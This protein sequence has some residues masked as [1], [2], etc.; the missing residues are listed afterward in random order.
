MDDARKQMIQQAFDTVAEGYD[1]P[2]LAFFSDT[3]ERMLVH[4]AMTDDLQLLDVCTGTGMLALKA[5]NQLARGRV[6]GIDLSSGMLKQASQKA[7]RLNL[8]NTDFVQ[9]DLDNLSLPANSFDVATSSFG[10]FFIE[11]MERAL[12]NIA[13]TVKPGGKVAISSFTGNAFQPFSEM[14]LEC[15]RSFGMDVPAL[16]W[17]RLETEEAIQ[18]V[19]NAAGITEVAYYYEP[20]KYEIKSD[21][22]WWDI[23]WNAGYRGFLNQ[24]SEDQCLEFERLHRE[25]ISQLCAQGDCWLDV[26][27]IIAIGT[28]ADE[29]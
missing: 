9:M 17:R 15:Y 14:F 6:K 23:V 2:S 29:K 1:H 13:A 20:L 21:Q 10:L 22:H 4:L 27:V 18:S 11:D 5:A 3:A 19:F 12:S 16:S 26:S 8:D 25:E 28:K 7:A 24:L